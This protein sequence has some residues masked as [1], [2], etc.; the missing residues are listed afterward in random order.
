MQPKLAKCCPCDRQ[1]PAAACHAR[2]SSAVFDLLAERSRVVL[3]AN[4]R[5]FEILRSLADVGIDNLPHQRKQFVVGLRTHS[6][7]NVISQDARGASRCRALRPPVWSLL[8]QPVFLSL[9]F[10]R[11]RWGA[12]AELRW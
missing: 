2:L 9:A 11:L 7:A 10:Q 3:H 6:L 1:D 5:W 8:F 4:F 12:M